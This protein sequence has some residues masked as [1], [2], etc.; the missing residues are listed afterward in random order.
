MLLVHVHH[1]AQPVVDEPVAR[2]FER[3]LDAAAAVVA[4][5]DHVLDAQDVDRVLQ[6]REAVEVGVDDDVRDVAV[7]EDLAR[8]ETDDLVGGNAAVGAADPEVLGCLPRDERSRSTAGRAATIAAAQARLFSKS[9]ERSPMTTGYPVRGGRRIDRMRVVTPRTIRSNDCC[10]MPW[11][12]GYGS[13]TELAVEP[14]DAALDRFDWRVSVAEL[15][16]SG[17]FSTF[18]GSDRII[19]QLDGPPMA[20]AHAGRPSVVLEHLVPYAFSGDDETTSTVDGVA[21]DFNLIV[22]RGV[23]AGLVAARSGPRTG[24]Q[25]RADRS[26]CSHCQRDNRHCRHIATRGREDGAPGDVEVRDAVDSALVVDDP[27]PGVVVHPRRSHVVPAPEVRRRIAFRPSFERPDSDPLQ[28]CAEERPDSIERP[29][30]PV[31]E[32]PGHPSAREPERIA[33]VPE[34]YA[35]RGGRL[36]LDEVPSI[37]AA[38]PPTMQTSVESTAS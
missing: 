15:R 38:P 17:P 16:G 7:D 12:N 8:R 34:G 19:V 21:H 14:P 13:T 25:L 30:D 37:P 23:A 4:A 27:P 35:T 32:A 22:R 24:I 20:L 10:V 6:D 11:K 31:G 28:F 18:P 29:V 36:G 5:D 26:R 33:A 2:A 3:G 9:S 1:V